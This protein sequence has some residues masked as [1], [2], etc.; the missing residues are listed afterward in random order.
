MNI[1]EFKEFAC[2]SIDYI[3]DYC[4]NIRDIPVLPKV[5]P[6]Y[7]SQQ[8]P[9]RAPEKGEPW[10]SVLEDVNKSIL[11]GLTQWHSPYFHAY[12]PT[13]QSYAAIIGELF[14]A[15]IGAVATNWESSPAV[16]ELEIRVMDWLAKILGLPEE[17]LNCSEGPGGGLI[18]NAASDSTLVGILSGSHKKIEQLH[19]EATP[20]TDSDIRGKLVAYTSTESNSSVE[21]SGLIASVKMRLLQP[22]SEGSLRGETLK[23][24]I[25]KDKLNGLIPFCV[26]ASLGTTGTC[27]MDNIAEIGLICAQEKMWLH[28]DAAY[29]GTVLA[30]PEYR[31]LSK[32]IERVDSFNFNPHKWMLTNGD[33]SAMWFRNCRYVEEAFKTKASL[34]VPKFIPEVE[35]MQIPDVRRFR[36]LKLW[37]VIRIYG[38]KGIQE[39]VRHQIYMAKYL[40]HLVN[41]DQ[42]FQVVISNL[43]VV[44]FKLLQNDCVTKEVLKR[45]AARKNIFI[46]PYYY[47]SELLFRFVVCSR[48]TRK[49]DIERSWNEISE[50]TTEVLR[51]FANIHC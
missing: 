47:K 33:C 43:G 48:F 6:G 15:G 18:Q 31:Y 1:Q 29:A 38:V 34:K 20:M 8:L 40:E 4:E 35:N 30:C 49:E 42:R 41:A 19:Q 22:D 51:D 12:F 25:E 39:H 16:V 7:L 17:F 36:A 24:A 23:N 5:E 46:M 10:Q 50:Q 21:K 11:P 37:F 3:A 14:M 26:V 44:C 9:K 27:A 2:A 32:G 13:G 45:L 28:V